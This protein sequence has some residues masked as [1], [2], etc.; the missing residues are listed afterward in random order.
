M[1]YDLASYVYEPINGLLE[2]PT[3]IR[4]ARKRLISQAKGR[5]LELGVGTGLNLPLYRNVE[6]VIGLDISRKM[7]EK[8]E[9]KG[10]KSRL[11]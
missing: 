4:N 5:V 10:L 11:S 1:R 3:G 8:G 7:L 6:E 9:G 2:R